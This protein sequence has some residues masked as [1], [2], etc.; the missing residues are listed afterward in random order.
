M[1]Q[2]LTP[3]IISL[4]GELDCSNRGEVERVL[5]AVYEDRVVL[6]LSRVR[7]M[8]CS[9]FGLVVAKR[10]EVEARGGYLTLWGPQRVVRRLLDILDCPYTP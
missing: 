9:V 4:H 1:L 3:T 5:A 10:C 8:D 7:F 6:D 2:L